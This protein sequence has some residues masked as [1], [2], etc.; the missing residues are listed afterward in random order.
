MGCDYGI[1]KPPSH[2]YH[3]LSPAKS[4]GR[5]VCTNTQYGSRSPQ[6]MMCRTSARPSLSS[7]PRPCAYNRSDQCQAL[8]TSGSAIRA[9]GLRKDYVDSCLMLRPR[10]ILCWLK[11]HGMHLLSSCMAEHHSHPDWSYVSVLPALPSRTLIGTVV[12]A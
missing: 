5:N 1:R 11:F 10:R 6:L 12:P 8:L 9:T 7:Y 4:R 2:H 3:L